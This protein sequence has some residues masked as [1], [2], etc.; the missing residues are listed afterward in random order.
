M[1]TQEQAGYRKVPNKEKKKRC[2]L[3]VFFRQGETFSSC[4]EVAG[5]IAEDGTCTLQQG[6]KIR[7]KWPGRKAWGGKERMGEDFY[8]CP[9][10]TGTGGY[11]S[12]CG[13]G[14]WEQGDPD[15][16]RP[17]TESEGEE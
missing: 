4:V 2:E 8:V 10:H 12:C 1:K 7:K 17:C 14:G 15:H 11:E 9:Q 5:I 3:C 6:R 13:C 16:G